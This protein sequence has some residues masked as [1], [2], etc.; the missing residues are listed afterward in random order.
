MIAISN[1]RNIKSRWFTYITIYVHLLTL[2][3][4]RG[5]KGEHIPDGKS[6]LMKFTSFDEVEKYMKAIFLVSST[7]CYFQIQYIKVNSA[8]VSS[9][10]D[11]IRKK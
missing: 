2:D 10:K 5:S 9:M 8:D 3:Y 1:T 6:I 11:Y 4:S 7:S